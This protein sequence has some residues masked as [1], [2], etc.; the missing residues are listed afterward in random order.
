[1]TISQ[2][3]MDV[4]ANAPQPNQPREIF[5]PNA[6]AHAAILYTLS[7]EIN[8]TVASLNNVPTSAGSVTNNTVSVGTKNFVIDP[9]KGYQKG[10]TVK[11]AADIA[12]THWMLGDVISY[13]DVTGAF[14]VEVSNTQNP[15][16]TVYSAWTVSL[17]FGGSTISGGDVQN[18]AFTGANAT[19]TGTAYVITPSPAITAYAANQSFFV[20]FNVVSGVAPT[21]QISGVGSPPNLVKQ[22]VDGSYVNITANDIPAN[23]RSRVTLL[24]ANQ[25]LVEDLPPAKSEDYILIREEQPNNTAGQNSVGGT[26]SKRALNTIVADTGSNVSLV[27]GVI[28]LA[29]GRYRFRARAPAIDSTKHKV[30]LA[31][32]ADT[33]YTVG[34]SSYSG[35]T[36]V[37]TDSEVS[38]RF[39]IAAPKTFELQHR[40]STSNTG[41]FGTP[42]NFGDIE[43]YASIELWKEKQ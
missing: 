28:T 34:V 30:R 6:F 7:L 24:S 33:T 26:Y 19:G 40:T 15:G 39:T 22:L 3:T 23:H 31:N 12:P 36:N 37:S 43:V 41:G 27:S 5:N 14:Q 21:L 18:Q 25:A 2:H 13:N 1:M 16:A 35:S 9:A 8:Q 20:T 17:A 32:T 29:P 38:G 4:L 42:S 11:I 10:M